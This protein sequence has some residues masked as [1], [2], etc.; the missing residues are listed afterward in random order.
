M[1]HI[2]QRSDVFLFLRIGAFVKFT[3][4]SSSIC[5][6]NCLHQLSTTLNKH[7]HWHRK[8]SKSKGNPHRPIVR[9]CRSGQLSFEQL[10]IVR[11]KPSLSTLMRKSPFQACRETL[12]TNPTQNRQDNSTS[13]NSSDTWVCPNHID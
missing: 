12:T 2:G 8:A 3:C 7:K 1:V 13:N 6:A 10:L 11:E 4:S 9:W 5:K